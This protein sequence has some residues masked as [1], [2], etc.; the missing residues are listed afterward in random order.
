LKISVLLLKQDLCVAQAGLKLR[1]PPISA[2]QAENTHSQPLALP[3]R[4]H[5]PFPGAY[6]LLA[7]LYFQDLLHWVFKAKY[8]S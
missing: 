4:G 6:K 1:D 8:E 5:L 7:K 3:E 2:S